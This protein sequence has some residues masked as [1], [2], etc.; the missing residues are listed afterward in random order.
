MFP[1]LETM[2]NLQLGQ[3]RNDMA[4]KKRTSK[5]IINPDVAV[6]LVQK[7]SRFHNEIEIPEYSAVI[8][9]CEQ[10]HNEI[11]IRNVEVIIEPQ[12]T[13]RQTV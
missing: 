4:R 11:E 6:I 7:C 5:A 2:L 12:R 10:L 8:Q 3:N 9:A 13:D 1:I